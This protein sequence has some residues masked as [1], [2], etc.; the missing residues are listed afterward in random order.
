MKDYTMGC[1][2]GWNKCENSLIH[3]LREQDLAIKQ[4]KAAVLS[5]MLRL[6]T[7]GKHKSLLQKEYEEL[8]K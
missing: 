2:D 4:L 6:I 3:K 1:V 8:N 5:E 7:F